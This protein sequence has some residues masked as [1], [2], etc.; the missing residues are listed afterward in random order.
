MALVE[1]HDSTELHRALET[2]ARIVGVNSRNLH[3]LSVDPE[4]LYRLAAEI[5]DRIVAVAESG[6]RMPAELHRLSDAGYDA[7]LV[8]ERLVSSPEPDRALR[9][10]RGA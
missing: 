1:V 10:L 9:E 5:P 2:D 3:T 4:T 6:L 8:G 7:F